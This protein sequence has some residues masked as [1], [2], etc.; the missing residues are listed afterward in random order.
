MLTD[1]N[2]Y[3]V[4]LFESERTDS[5]REWGWSGG[6]GREKISVPH[7]LESTLEFPEVSVLGLREIHVRAL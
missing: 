4:H 6:T 1:F 5:E 3:L 7:P 2:I